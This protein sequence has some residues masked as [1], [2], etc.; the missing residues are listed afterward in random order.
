MDSNSEL[1]TRIEEVLQAEKKNTILHRLYPRSD[2]FW[3]I[4]CA[5][6]GSLILA[7]GILSVI[8]GFEYNIGFF[9]ASVFVFLVAGGLFISNTTKTKLVKNRGYEICHCRVI[10]RNATRTRYSTDRKVTV[11]IPSDG[12]QQTY[13]VTA[14][15]YKKAIKN[16]DALLV[17]YTKE[18]NGKR[19]IPIDVV[20]PG[21]AED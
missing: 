1:E 6:F 9:I 10:S 13:K 16:T 3:G 14:E 21:L 7:G 12:N 20:I 19:D 15:T 17:D 8:D 11:I 2:I 4:V 18:H 5:G